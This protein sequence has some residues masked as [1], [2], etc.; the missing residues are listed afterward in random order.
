M[1][2]KPDKNGIF[3]Y[4]K[5][6][7]MIF[8]RSYTFKTTKKAK[9]VQNSIVGKHVEVHK[10]DFEVFQND[11]VIRIIPH[12]EEHDEILTLPISRVNIQEDEKG[13]TV[14]IDTHP[15][16][17]DVGGPYLLLLICVGAFIGGFLLRNFNDGMYTDVGTYF[18]LGALATFIIFWIK[19]ELGYFDYV[20]KLSSW[21]KKQA[22][23]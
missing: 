18:M 17:I 7:L 3:R 9:E 22:L 21:V 1:I 2:E 4:T 20:R 8:N 6:Y 5:I 16:K 15:R 14:R 13:S 19:M 11:E 23:A 12:A 10:I